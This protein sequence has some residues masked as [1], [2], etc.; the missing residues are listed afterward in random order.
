MDAVPADVVNTPTLTVSPS[1]AP[2][3]HSANALRHG[4]TGK[5]LLPPELRA[6]RVEEL[7]E[8]LVVEMQPLAAGQDLSPRNCAAR[9]GFGDD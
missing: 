5:K 4:L 6:G 3:S 7:Y 8:Q 1:G 2:S 9:S